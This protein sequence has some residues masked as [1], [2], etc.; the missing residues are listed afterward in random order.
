M[1]TV[2]GEVLTEELL[3][4]DETFTLSLTKG[5]MAGDGELLEKDFLTGTEEVLIEILLINVSDLAQGT[6]VGKVLSASKLSTKLD[7]L[8][9][10]AKLTSGCRTDNTILHY[11]EKSSISLEALSIIVEENISL[12]GCFSI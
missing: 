12:K 1:L 10:A 8:L 9:T 5:F 7:K 4:V 2:D 3:T 11:T 6:S